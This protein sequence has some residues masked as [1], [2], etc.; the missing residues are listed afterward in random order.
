M[1]TLIKDVFLVPVL[2]SILLLIGYPTP[3][4][5]RSPLL[6][7]LNRTIGTVGR[8]ARSRNAEGRETFITRLLR[9]L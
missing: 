5:W 7:S 8:W 9:N 3:D 6:I 2:L 4:G 1:P